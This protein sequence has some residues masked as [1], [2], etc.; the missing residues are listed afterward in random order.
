MQQDIKQNIND[1]EKKDI[2]IDE[3]DKQYSEYMAVE[4]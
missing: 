2:E 3:H 1:I 4:N